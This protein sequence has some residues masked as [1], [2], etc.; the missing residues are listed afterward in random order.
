MDDLRRFYSN[1]RPFVNMPA[2]KSIEMQAARTV[3]RMM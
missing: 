3:H 1:A 2:G